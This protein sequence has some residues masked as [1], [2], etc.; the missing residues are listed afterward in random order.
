MTVDNTVYQVNQT[1]NGSATTFA[2]IEF[3]VLETADVV[4]TQVNNT[5]G[6]R[7]LQ[8]E[9]TDYTITLS[10]P[11]D[12][13]SN[14]DVE[15]VVAPA[16][17][18]TVEIRRARSK[19]QGIVFPTGGNFP[20]N[21]ANFM[22]DSLA[23]PHIDDEHFRKLRMS[24]LTFAVNG[25]N[26]TLDPAEYY[27]G[28]YKFTGSPIAGVSNL[29]L[30]S[31]VVMSGW[32]HNKYSTAG[33]FIDVSVSGGAGDALSDVIGGLGLNNEN[34]AYIYSDGADVDCVFASTDFS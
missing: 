8:T 24:R 25:G 9:T 21:S 6:R 10:N 28:A 4:V 1:G 29:L 22:G 31:G 15:F 5:T 34:S 18:V 16:S 7:T 13:P 32:L 2:V 27:Y 19:L 23:M 11:T 30:P 3:E 26:V 14:F 33:A 20:S 12:L 17:G